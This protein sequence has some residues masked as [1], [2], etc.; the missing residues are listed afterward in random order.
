MK[1]SKFSFHFIVTLLITGVIT[2]SCRKDMLEK[3]SNIT[4]LDS[5]KT[6]YQTANKYNLNNQLGL[7]LNPQWLN[8]VIVK[9]ES[10]VNIIGT[11]LFKNDSIY[12]ELNL[13]NANKNGSI[14]I[15]KQYNWYSNKLFIFEFNEKTRS[16]VII[17]NYQI[18]KD[19]FKKKIMGIKDQVLDEVIVTSNV[20][21]GNVLK[22]LPTNDFFYSP[23]A[24]KFLSESGG[25]G[26]VTSGTSLVR[27]TPNFDVSALNKYPKFKNL[28]SNLQSFLKKF[29]NVLKALKEYTGLSEVKILELMKPGKGPKIIPI[30]NLNYKGNDC[31]GMFNKTTGTIEI[32]E[33]YVK[34]FEVAQSDAAIQ[35]TGMLLTIVTLHEFVHFGRDINSL[36]VDIN[37]Y[38]AGWMFE[39]NIS[40]PRG[41]TKIE[42]TNAYI[43]IKS[44]P[45]N[46]TK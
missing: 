31:Y 16:R 27:K 44:Y 35:A 32:N 42:D 5:A 46:F 19:C 38:E 22:Y 7:N 10:G 24:D 28:A 15:I 36:S 13:L 6:W 14:G 26:G 34:G 45:Y 25:G 1:N 29:P 40:P 33:N 17:A 21:S 43:W 8:S 3:Q 12:V 41:T 18:K 39:S 4:L 23:I 37:G 9:N 11:T 20:G 30:P 2:Q